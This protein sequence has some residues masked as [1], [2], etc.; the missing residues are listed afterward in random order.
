MDPLHVKEIMEWTAKVHN[1]EIVFVGDLSALNLSPT[2]MGLGARQD[3]LNHVKVLDQFKKV[4]G[5]DG[6][7]LMNCGN[8]GHPI[9]PCYCK[10]MEYRENAHL[11]F[12]CNICNGRPIGKLYACAE[13]DDIVYNLCQEC[14]D[15]YEHG[16]GEMQVIEKPLSKKELSLQIQK[17]KAVEKVRD[18]VNSKRVSFRDKIWEMFFGL[19]GY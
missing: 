10:C 12:Y 5:L 15:Q 4:N 8:T 1:S 3:V 14:F 13:C 7:V 19:R 16:C 6:T 18:P 11:E 2:M 9:Q 17:W